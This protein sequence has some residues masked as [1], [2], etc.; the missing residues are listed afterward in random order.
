MEKA[1]PHPWGVGMVT[2][3]LKLIGL[4]EG[5][6]QQSGDSANLRLVCLVEGGGKRAVWGSVGSQ[7]NIDNVQ[8]AEIPC[9]VECECVPP[10]PWAV[11]Y[12]HT[13]WV[14]QVRRLRVLSK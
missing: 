13:L 14:P 2:K 1:G 3:T 12:G 9:E 5:G 6:V 7:E 11:R 10:E 8:R 4:D